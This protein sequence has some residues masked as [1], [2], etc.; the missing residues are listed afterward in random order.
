MDPDASNWTDI[1]GSAHNGACGFAF[2]DGHSEIKK[3]QSAAS[4]YPVIF[5]SW[6]GGIRRPFD[7]TGRSDFAWFLE[8]S[9][10]IMANSGIPRYGY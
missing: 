10:F 3:W 6:Q 9:G 8:R 2:A 4:R 7:A 5:L 1:P